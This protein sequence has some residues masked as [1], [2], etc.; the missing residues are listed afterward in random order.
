MKFLIYLLPLYSLFSFS[1]TYVPDDNFE[2][3]LIDLGYDDVLDDYV[4]TA[5]I[6][7]VVSLDVSLKNIADLTGIEDFSGLTILNCEAN[8]LPVINLTQNLLLED[9]KC[10][11]NELTTLGISNNLQLK[12]LGC[13]YNLLSSLDL[14]AN[15]NLEQC[16]CG[17][18]PLL[19]TLDFSENPLMEYINCSNG[20]VSSLN[21]SN[22]Q[23]LEKLYCSHN[24]LASLDVT[25]NPNLVE[26]LCAVNNLTSLDVSNNPL[27]QTLFIYVNQ[28]TTL[29][30][31]NNVNLFA[32]E[33][34]Y[35][36]LAHLDLSHNPM[37][38]LYIDH[39]NLEYIDFRNGVNNYI[40]EALVSDNPNLTCI[41]VDDVNL[42]DE[43]LW[44]L[45]DQTAFVETEAQ[46]AALAVDGFE[47]EAVAVY[48]NP[49]HSS[50]AVS[51]LTDLKTV[52]LYDLRGKLIKTYEPNSVYDTAGIASGLY[53]VKIVS[54]QATNFLK[55]VVD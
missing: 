8:D 43:Q 55:L 42:I 26:L 18:N 53:V 29:D 21:V 7:N 12:N 15:V 46:Y 39:N 25:N 16:I 24:N 30:L 33:G 3:A 44:T 45:D 41:Y 23:I 28:L 14:A 5:N 51:G 36:Q 49:C 2:Q 50:F 38:I 35:N 4:A 31:S 52:E 27:L 22:N 54:E 17:G 34:Q 19:T 6:A 10:G 47:N 1:Q 13:S 48:P 32:I 11:G 37:V 40:Q 9:L 20:S